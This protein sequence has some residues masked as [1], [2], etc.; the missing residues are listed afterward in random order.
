MIT[1]LSITKRDILVIYRHVSENFE[2]KQEQVENMT[3]KTNVPFTLSFLSHRMLSWRE[4]KPGII[5]FSQI[6]PHF[7]DG[8][9][10]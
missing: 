9:N 7:R 8:K 6:V 5:F 3:D 4:C 10:R 1:V 2:M